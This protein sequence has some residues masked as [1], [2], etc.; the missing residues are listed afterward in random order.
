[1][2]GSDGNERELERQINEI[3]ENEIE[4]LRTRGFLVWLFGWHSRFGYIHSYSLFLF[5]CIIYV[6][7]RIMY[8]CECACV[9]AVSC[10]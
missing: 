8:M 10:I 2:C 5:L 3:I 9:W 1:M 4:F 7:P 6:I